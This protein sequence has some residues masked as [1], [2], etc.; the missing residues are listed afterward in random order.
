MWASGDFGI[1]GTTLQIVGESL[2]E[3]VDLRSGSLVLDVAAGN[4]N[5]ARRPR[6]AGATSSPPTTCLSCSRT[7]AAAPAGERLEIQFEVADAE[8]LPYPDASFDVV[9]S[10][11]CVMFAPNHSRTAGELLRV[12]RSGGKIG[13]ANWTP[14]GFIGQLFR[15]V[16]ALRA[17]VSGADAARA[18]GCGGSPAGAV[19]GSATAWP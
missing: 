12:C 14:E 13:M 6:A 16:G 2:C 15:V 18:L 17:A 9:L 1:I 3:A 7:A 5:C 10:S 4:G 8:A 19:R 11:F